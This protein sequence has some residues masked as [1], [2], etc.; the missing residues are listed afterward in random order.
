MSQRLQLLHSVRPPS[1]ET[2]FLKSS[3]GDGNIPVFVCA[4]GASARVR[5]VG[6]VVV[7]VGVLAVGVLGCWYWWC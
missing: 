3:D 2:E 1:T 5:D 6:F 7:V 4:L